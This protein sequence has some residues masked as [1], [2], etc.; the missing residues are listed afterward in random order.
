MP[1]AFS[2]PPSKVNKK[3]LVLSVLCFI[4]SLNCFLHLDIFLSLSGDPRGKIYVYNWWFMIK[5]LNFGQGISA[6][7]RFRNPA[8]TLEAPGDLP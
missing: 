5:T 8:A 6:V 3:D 4:I 7:S 2:K 1:W